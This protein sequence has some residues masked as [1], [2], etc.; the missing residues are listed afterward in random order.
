MTD[1]QP[2]IQ[3]L[4]LLTAKPLRE[5]K[6]F[7]QSLLG[8]AILAEDNN[9]LTIL[10]GQTQIIFQQATNDQGEPFYHF[11]F[12][13]PQN[14]LMLARE[15]LLQRIVLIQTPSNRR[16]SRYPDDIRHFPDWNAHA[17]FFW[18]P[19]G[20]I[21][22]FIA[23]HDVANDSEGPF[24]ANDILYASEIGFVVEDQQ[25]SAQQLEEMLHLKPYPRGTSFA[26]A[27][28]DERGLLLCTPK[29]RSWGDNTDRPKIFDIF[30]TAVMI[31]GHQLGT[32]SLPGYPYQIHVQT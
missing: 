21:V 28:G 9:E 8:F 22:E 6:D 32:Y 3:T 30:P 12:D 17:L 26:W 27:M 16:D 18:D 13:I 7:Y 19:A 2:R 11:A 20:N 31:R 14:K 15:W 23:R 24:T 25:A 10:G 5:M 4:R 29:G 1:H